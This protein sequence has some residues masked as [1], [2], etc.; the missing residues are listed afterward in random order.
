MFPG[1]V[2]TQRESRPRRNYL[3]YPLEGFRWPRA[4]FMF[5]TNQIWPLTQNTME[6]RYVW[7]QITESCCTWKMQVLWHKFL[8]ATVQFIRCHIYWL[9]LFLSATNYVILAAADQSYLSEICLYICILNV[10]LWYLVA[11]TL[12]FHMT[13]NFHDM[14]FCGKTLNISYRKTSIMKLIQPVFVCFLKMFGCAVLTCSL[15]HVK[16]MSQPRQ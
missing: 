14:I 13:K 10:K 12:V 4:L 9:T 16:P 7:I 1:L 15:A 8:W 6:C 11:K 5:Q 2:L 3:R